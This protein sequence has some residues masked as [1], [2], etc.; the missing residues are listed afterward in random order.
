MSNQTVNL[1]SRMLML[2]LASCRVVLWALATHGPRL[3]EIL[4]GPFGRLLPA[5]LP[6]VLEP[7]L[8]QLAEVLRTARDFLIA[9]DRDHR[10]QKTLLRKFRQLRDDAQEELNSYVVDLRNCWMSTTFV[11]QRQLD[12]CTHGG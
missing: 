8:G 6:E 12:L 4:N 2:R 7:L 10:D 1:P 5:T 11:H 9:S 3:V